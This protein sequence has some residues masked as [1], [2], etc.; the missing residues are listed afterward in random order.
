MP[1]RPPVRHRPY[2]VLRELANRFACAECETPVPA[3]DAWAVFI[4]ALE[5]QN[6]NVKAEAHL[7]CSVACRDALVESLMVEYSFVGVT[8]IETTSP[9]AEVGD[10]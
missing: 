3:G 10:G 1:E 9:G 2:Y 6:K 8:K 5:D 4:D 7:T